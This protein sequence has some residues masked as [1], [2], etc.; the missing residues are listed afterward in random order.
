MANV[1]LGAIVSHLDDRLLAG[2]LTLDALRSCCCELREEA[3]LPDVA[4][5]LLEGV[6]CG[7]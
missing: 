4:H 1:E 3:Y 6:L 5:G 7:A 2:P